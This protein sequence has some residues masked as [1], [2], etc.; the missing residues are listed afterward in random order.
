MP[1]K[2]K[3]KAQTADGDS[4]VEIISKCEIIYEYT[5]A[6]TEIEPEFIWGQ[7]YQ[8]IKDQAVL[9]TGLEDIPIYANTRKSSIMKVSTHPEIFLCVEVIG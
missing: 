3:K 7:I 6:I 5:K 8:M 1:K 4:E 2:G 9:D